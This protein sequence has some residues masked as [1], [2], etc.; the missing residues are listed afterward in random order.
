MAGVRAVQG[1]PDP[2]SVETLADLVRELDLLRARA[3]RG[4]RKARVS[5]D[6]LA[7]RVGMPRSTVHAHISGV[8]VPPIDVLDRIVIALDASPDEQ[9]WW[10]EAWYR[11]AARPRTPAGR[12]PPLAPRQLPPDVSGFTGRADSLAALDQLLDGAGPAVA[13]I[14]GTAGVGKTALA[15]RWA[16]RVAGRFPD[17]QLY[18]NLRGYDPTAPVPPA[19][20]VAIALRDLGVPGADIRP[21]LGEQVN[22]YRTLLAD[23]R[24]LVVLDNVNS[25]EQVRDLLPGSPSCFVVVTS[26]DALTGLVARDGARRIDLG[27]LPA[28]DALALLRSLIGA[29]VDD[30]PAAAHALIERCARLPLALRIAAD[31]AHSRPDR[32]LAVLVDELSDELG[33]LDVLDAGGDDQTA[34]RAV[35]SWSYRN[36]SPG[37]ARFF[38]LLGCQPGRHFDLHT[39]AAVT[40]VDLACAGRSLAELVRTHLVEP[41]DADRYRMHDLLRAY[42][43][44]LAAAEPEHDRRTALTGLLDY[45][46]FAAAAAM[47]QVYPSERARRPVVPVAAAALPSMTCARDARGWLDI[48]ID[49]LATAIEFAAAQGFAEHVAD[50][51]GT[52]WRHLDTTAR[53]TEAIAVHTCALTSA[54]AADDL[55]AEASS[56]RHLGI[57]AEHQG[58]YEDAIEHFERSLKIRGELGDDAGTASVLTTIGVVLEAM[59]RFDEAISGHRRALDLRRTA[60]DRHGEA[61]TLLNL[62]IAQE[63]RGD[64]DLAAEQHRQALRLYREMADR[65]GEAHALNNLGNALRRLDEGAGALDHHERALALYRDLGSREGEAFALAGLGADLHR[66]GHLDDSVQRHEQALVIAGEIGLPGL[67]A[68]VLNN[69]G[70]TLLDAGRADDAR[71]AHESALAVAAEHDDRLE[72]ARASHGL[73]RALRAAGLSAEAGVHLRA[74]LAMYDRL[75]VPAPDQQPG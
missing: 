67:R 31:R 72:L 4:S 52:L 42:A 18:L 28:S 27:L 8:T 69:L 21:T 16:H 65:L 51:A 64:H 35:F 45:Y 41:F 39:A 36:L 43:A 59:G 10:S 33:R 9:A 6:E 29:R 44:E 1:G 23:R 75:G 40:G 12:P 73:S 20:A 30:D 68:E 74:A 66:L 62:G 38:R 34:V 46:R 47:D 37:A 24:V 70:E 3:A 13:A 71:V 50:L 49:N 22:Q 57:V 2:G 11:V 17:G 54:R 60:G 25:P 5:I 15:L 19:A 63:S 56:L 58:R 7:A 14:S 26:R 53:W 61:T 48:E 32:P 55:A